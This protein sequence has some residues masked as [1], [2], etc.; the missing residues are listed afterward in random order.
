MEPV[1]ASLIFYCKIFIKQT[2]Q[3]YIKYLKTGKGTSKFVLQKNPDDNAMLHENFIGKRNMKIMA[4][5]IVRW[6]PLSPP[7]IF[8]RFL[9][10]KTREKR[11]DC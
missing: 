1:V 5:V 8:D 2:L 10:V 3:K 4:P 11:Y 9:S 6:S 7:L